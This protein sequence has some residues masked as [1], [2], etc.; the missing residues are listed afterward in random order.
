MF[1]AFVDNPE[2]EEEDEVELD[3]NPLSWHSIN[4]YMPEL[5]AR[6]VTICHQRSGDSRATAIFLREK[7]HNCPKFYVVKQ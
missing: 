1:Q 7:L 2:P 5:E 4:I 3:N 6:G